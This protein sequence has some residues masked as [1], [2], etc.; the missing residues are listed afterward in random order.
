LNA[1][2][3][4]S[5]GVPLGF[6]VAALALLLVCVVAAQRLFEP[7]ARALFSLALQHATAMAALLAVFLAA[8]RTRARALVFVAVVAYLLVIQADTLS[9][10][11]ISLPADTVLRLLTSRTDAA[12]VLQQAHVSGTD[13][14]L[15]LSVVALE[16]AALALLYRRRRPV[17]D[18]GRWRRRAALA[19]A[20]LAAA[21]VGEQALSRHDDEY[22]QRTAVLPGYYRVFASD[23]GAVTFACE[24]PP[25]SRFD[26]AVDGVSGARNPRNLILILLESFRYDVLTPALAPNLEALTRESLSFTEAYAASTGTSRVWNVLLLNRPAH[27]FLRDREAEAADGGARRGAFPARV[28]KKAGYQVMVSLGC[29]FD[30]QGYRERF[31][32]T[33]GLVDRYFSSYP[34]HNRARHVADDRATEE[35][36]RWLGE[37]GLKKP[38]FL[39]THLDSTHFYYFF[40]EEK[41]IVRPYA[42]ALTTR[43]LLDRSP[44]SRD[45]LYNRYQ[46]AVAQ[47]DFNVGR[48]LDAVAKAGLADDT[49]IV[50]VADHGQSFELGRFG[51]LQV[52]Q[53]TKHVPLLMRLPG[54][55]R[56]HVS[57]LVTDADVF[58][59]LF[60]YLGIEGLDP[61]ALLGRSAR[62]GP[63]R[64]SVLTLEAAMRQAHLTFPD[65]SVVLD[66]D[67]ADDRMLTFA[68]ISVIGRDG[69]PLPHWRDRL[70]TVPWREELR[71]GLGE[72]LPDESTRASH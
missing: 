27:L 47:A 40:H 10:A 22:L 25:E 52:S 5:A 23:L 36:L 61:R 31:M 13:V 17:A 8:R 4:D 32:G 9:M 67:A 46:N 57:R 44:E 24:R 34:G 11:V 1:R 45:L 71:R 18:G 29:N 20:A 38:F 37:P 16:T 55:A 41:A 19:A 54:V 14:A 30:W 65:L 53:A 50:V 62:S 39:L 35:I 42:A 69:R 48:I 26:A 49:A 15:P 66:L 28:L 59:T 2:G 12:A 70:R 64:R 72:G 60:D 63:E 6:G 51:H 56:G 43:R 3:S 33:E 7:P 68:P 58:P 21:F